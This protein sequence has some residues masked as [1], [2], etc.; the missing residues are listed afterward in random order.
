MLQPAPVVIFG[1]EQI[2]RHEKSSRVIVAQHGD[3]D[4]R[5]AEEIKRIRRQLH[6]ELFPIQDP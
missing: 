4:E 1:E 3:R 2:G 5:V 6:A